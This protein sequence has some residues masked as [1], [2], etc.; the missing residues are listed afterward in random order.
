MSFPYSQ[1]SP[2]ELDDPLADP[3]LS[4]P[5]S[6][7]FNRRQSDAYASVDHRIEHIE[8]ALRAYRQSFNDHCQSASER[9]EILIK[10]LTEHSEKLSILTERLTAHEQRFSWVEKLLWSLIGAVIAFAGSSIAWALQ[11][12]AST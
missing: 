6:H 12:V 10:A 1:P 3:S 9:L 7:S 2:S 11:H 5:V 8:D 4:S